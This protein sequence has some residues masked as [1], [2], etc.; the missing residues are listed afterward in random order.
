MLVTEG[1]EMTFDKL[2]RAIEVTS[3]MWL[4]LMP[5]LRGI[6]AHYDA[7]VDDESVGMTDKD[8]ARGRNLVAKLERVLEGD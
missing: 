6:V 8:R 2:T 4:R 7:L 3:G 1:G 5:V